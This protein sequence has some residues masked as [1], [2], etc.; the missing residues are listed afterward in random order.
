MYL[1]H[2]WFIFNSDLL[3]TIYPWIP[4]IYCTEKSLER[5]EILIE[6]R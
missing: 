5:D 6:L 4:R 3:G 2:S 1:E